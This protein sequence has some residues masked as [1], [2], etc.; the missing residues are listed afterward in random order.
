M[1][2]FLFEMPITSFTIVNMAVHAC[3]T[4]RD[5]LHHI[6]TALLLAH[7]T[8]CL[9]ESE[10][11]SSDHEQV[12]AA[13]IFVN[14][15]GL[16]HDEVNVCAKIRSGVISAPDLYLRV[17]SYGC[18]DGFLQEG[19]SCPKVC[20]ALTYGRN[21]TLTCY[22][23]NDGECNHTN[24]S[25]DCK[26][27]W[28]GQHCER[29]CPDGWYGDDCGNSCPCQNGGSCHPVTGSCL[30]PI[31][32]A[33]DLC[34]TNCQASSTNS[35]CQS[36]SVAFCSLCSPEMLFCDNILGRCVCQDG[37]RGRYCTHSC[38]NATQGYLCRENCQCV[39]GAS[40]QPTD[41]RCTCLPGWVGDYCD[42]RCPSGYFGD[43]CQQ[44]CNCPEDDGCD[45]VGGTCFSCPKGWKGKLC[46]LPCE[47]NHWGESCSQ[48]CI[49]TESEQ[50]EPISGTCLESGMDLSP[51]VIAAIA[52][53]VAFLLFA[54][55]ITAVCILCKYNRPKPNTPSVA[56]VSQANGTSNPM[57][58]MSL[59]SSVP[60]TNGTIRYQAGN[61]DLA[62]TP[63][64]RNPA[65][66]TRDV[67]DP[68]NSLGGYETIRSDVDHDP[69]FQPSPNSYIDIYD[70]VQTGTVE[71]PTYS[72]IDA[73]GYEIPS[74]TL[75]RDVE[76]P[77]AGG[78][79][80]MTNSNVA[81]RDGF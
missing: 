25:C 74:V 79:A 56:L 43:D 6:A 62:P 16:I 4:R 7:G 52:A 12:E 61:V 26:P 33:G 30:C 35:S 32:F 1:T 28:T 47:D 71:N 31:D 81:K 37:W 72:G 18:C 46:T 77:S 69:R 44:Q 42:K 9:S 64:P 76:R 51:G 41:G 21:C 49:C 70:E 13:W 80:R 39:N 57:S 75:E 14:P 5:V 2:C 36:G 48:T 45:H 38:D 15:F 50:C 54:I 19:E 53:S 40:C 29:T 58:R 11:L 34:Q 8:L 24:G 60:H 68:N 63:L 3:H 23:L 65:T 55:I 66:F 67:T 10:I 78:N 22:C 27:G 17:K 73:D 20:P 59:Q